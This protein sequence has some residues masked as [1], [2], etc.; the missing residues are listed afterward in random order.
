MNPR[1]RE[2]AEQATD[3]WV[4]GEFFDRE[5]FAQLIILECTRAVQDDTTQGDHY[6]QRIEQYFGNNNDGILHFKDEQ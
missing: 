1:I 6:A 4:G 3:K 2:L 5:K